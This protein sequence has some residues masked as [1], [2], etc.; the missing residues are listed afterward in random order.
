MGYLCGFVENMKTEWATY[1]NILYKVAC[2]NKTQ[3]LPLMKQFI[4]RLVEVLC[5]YVSVRP[6][7]LHMQLPTIVY[8]DPRYLIYL[9]REEPFSRIFRVQHLECVGIY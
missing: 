8:K 9:K 2:P 4:V 1:L 3:F 7:I 6:S 5:V